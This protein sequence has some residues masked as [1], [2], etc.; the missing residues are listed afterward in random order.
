VGAGTSLLAGAI[1]GQKWVI[2]FAPGTYENIRLSHK[3]PKGGE[4]TRAT[5]RGNIKMRASFEPK[6]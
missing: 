2:Y 6:V 1:L 3:K 4:L 5:K